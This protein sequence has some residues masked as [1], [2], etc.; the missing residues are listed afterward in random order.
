MRSHG[1]LR[2]GHFIATQQLLANERENPSKIF[3]PHSRKSSQI[4]TTQA[5]SPFLSASPD[6]NLSHELVIKI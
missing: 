6:L 3:A 1:V 2:Q 4:L 5:H